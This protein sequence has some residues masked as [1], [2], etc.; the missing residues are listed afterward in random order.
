MPAQIYTYEFTALNEAVE[1]K[2]HAKHLARKNLHASSTILHVQENSNSNSRAPRDKDEE[3]IFGIVDDLVC[4]V[5]DEQED[6]SMMLDSA[7]DVEAAETLATF[8]ISGI[9]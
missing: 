7:E 3:I 4:T 2:R 5:E 9:E 1:T 6:A 8:G